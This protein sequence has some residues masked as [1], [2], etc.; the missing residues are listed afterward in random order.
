VGP[1]PTSVSDDPEGAEVLAECEE[2]WRLLP[3]RLRQ[4]IQLVCLPMDDVEE[5]AVM[6]NAIQRFATVVVQKSLAEGFGLTVTE[7]MWKA[8]PIVASSVGGIPD[9]IDDG[10]HGVLVDPQDGRQFAAAVRSLVDEPERATHL[11]AN[12]RTRV[13]ERFLCDRHLGQHAELLDRLLV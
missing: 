2:T 1:D 6:V 8:R 7:A 9:Q 13:Q 4:R 11:G 12:A 10:H 3:Q 5:N